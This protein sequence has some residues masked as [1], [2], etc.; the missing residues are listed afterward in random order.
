M[1][2]YRFVALKV[3][4]AERSHVSCWHQACVAKSDFVYTLKVT[5]SSVRLFQDDSSCDIDVVMCEIQNKWWIKSF[6]MMLMCQRSKRRKR[7]WWRSEPAAIFFS[8]G[9][10]WHNEDIPIKFNIHDNT[11]AAFIGTQNKGYRVQQKVKK[12]QC[13]SVVIPQRLHF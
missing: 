12:Q 6:D 8:P 5:A 11:V 4:L 1:F 13:T 7:K 2:A 9:G 3:M 10:Y